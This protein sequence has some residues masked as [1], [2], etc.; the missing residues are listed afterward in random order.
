MGASWEGFVIEQLVRQY[1]ERGAYFWATHGGAELDLLVFD[2]GA[3]VGFEV[4]LTDAPRT[5]RSMRSAIE[6][7]GLWQLN[8]VYPGERAFAL[9]DGI[10]A[11]PIA[12][13]G[14]TR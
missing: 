10:T 8:V 2:D 5:T 6:D 3:P 9:D 14:A 12:Q 13:L 11:L 1:S 4:K 7:L